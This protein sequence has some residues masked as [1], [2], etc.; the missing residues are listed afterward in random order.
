MYRC[1]LYRFRRDRS[2]KPAVE[3]LASTIKVARHLSFPV[4]L[5]IQHITYE[6]TVST[7][8]EIFEMRH[9]FL[10]HMHSKSEPVSAESGSSVSNV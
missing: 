2:S 10:N 8:I 5:L 3:N 1:P 7:L 9:A 6:V 4:V